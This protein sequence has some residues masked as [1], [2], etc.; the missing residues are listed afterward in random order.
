MDE[1]APASPLPTIKLCE[2]VLEEEDTDFPFPVPIPHDSVTLL[3]GL[4]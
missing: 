1:G 2:S 4:D 3:L